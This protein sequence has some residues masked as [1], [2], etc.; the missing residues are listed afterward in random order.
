MS[1]YPVPTMPVGNPV[2]ADPYVIAGMRN[3][4]VTLNVFIP[5]IANYPFI[6]DPYMPWRRGNWANNYLV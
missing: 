6:F 5:A 3:S 1:G 4:P 2:T